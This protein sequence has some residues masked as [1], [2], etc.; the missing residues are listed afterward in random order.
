M[1]LS[2]I[3]LAAGQGT[4][5]SSNL[6]K[7]LAPLA[8]RPLLAHVIDASNTLNADAT[9]IVVGFGADEVRKA[10]A[11]Q[12]L[13]WHEQTERK[14][15]GHAVAQAIGAVPDSH[16]V[17][18]L[19]GDVP[20]V[21]SE[22]LKNLVAS[23]GSKDLAVLTARLDDPTGYGRI[24]RAANGSV[25][26]IVEQ[27][28]AS[29]EEAAIHE[30]NTGLIACPAAHLKG[31][32]AELEPNNVQG[33]Y[34]LT[35]IIALAVRDAVPVHAVAAGSAAETTGINDRT[36][37]ADCEAQMRASSAEALLKHGVTLADPKRID[38]R[39]QLDCGKDVFIDI[40]VVF[41]GKV[42]LGDGVRIGPNNV[43]SDSQ[44]EDGTEV[45]P[46][47]VIDRAHIGPRC[48]I[49]PFARVR[50]ESYLG[51][52]VK[53]GNFVETKKSVIAKGSKVNHLSYVGDSVIGE[54]VNV[55]AGTI[56]CNYDGVNK[57]QTRIDD[58]AFIGSG[59]QLVAPVTVGANATI[60]AGSVISKDAPA[61]ELTVARGKQVTL[62]GWKRPEKL[63]KNTE[64]P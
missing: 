31:W 36:Q 49:G 37:L 47:C 52:E 24:V 60:G 43:I 48:N 27:R 34:Y 4:R 23:A 56:T 32:L 35:D 53:I 45:L 12:P 61:D 22:T 18:V 2:I 21:Q 15:T 28:D 13:G 25:S 44:I 6:P 19:Y 58:G 3:I 50:P 59:T 38:V 51:S 10:F 55:G 16:T 64:K 40:N 62:R 8:G 42:K 29:A 39:G 9:H 26:C 17:L 11:G 57:Y 33:E 5:M 14:G 63:A 54:N 30:V 20:L 46:N 7:V 1:P 41:T